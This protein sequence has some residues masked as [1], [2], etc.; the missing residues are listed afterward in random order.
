MIAISNNPLRIAGITADS[1]ILKL[2]DVVKKAA[3][4]QELDTN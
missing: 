2:A 3:N 4:L 1:A